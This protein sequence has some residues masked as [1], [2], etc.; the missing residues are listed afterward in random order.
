VLAAAALATAWLTPAGARH[1]LLEGSP[2][3]R[4]LAA[5]ARR[6]TLP[7]AA[8]WRDRLTSLLSR[9]P[10]GPGYVWV[11]PAGRRSLHSGHLA[12]TGLLLAT[13][14]LY[15]ALGIANRPGAG[16]PLSGSCR[17]WARCCWC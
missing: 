1:G 16:I 6:R 13:L 2:W 14:A 10:F 7:G 9:G 17:R 11:D 3:A 8:W 12:S 5:F 4:R 15:L